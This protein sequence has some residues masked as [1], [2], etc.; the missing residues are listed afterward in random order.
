MKNFMLLAA[1]LLTSICGFAR[2]H[3]NE[4]ATVVSDTIYYD[5]NRVTVEGSDKA[6]YYR[7]LLTQNNGN[8]KEDVFADY[9]MDGTMKAEGG[10]TFVDL[11]DDANTV[12]DGKVTT[13]YKNG[14][15]KLNGRYVNG[16]REGYFTLQLRN[17][18][19]AIIQ[20]HNGVSKYDYY[21]ETTPDGVQKKRSLATISSLLQ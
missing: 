15:E 4:T 13:Y 21:M 10:Y 12:L 8:E 17:G 14:K 16:K 20:Y 3:I 6:A 9:Y 2:T 11:G 1:M 18:N 7:L 19:I 5:A